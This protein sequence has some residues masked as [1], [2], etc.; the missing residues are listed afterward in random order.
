MRVRLKLGGHDAR[1]FETADLV[2][3]SPGVPHTLPMLEPA[4]VN[5]I[6]VVGEMELA[7]GYISEPMLAV[8]GTNGKTTTTELVG[9]MLKNSGK[10]VFVGG[11]IGTPL[12]AYADGAYPRADVV[13]VETSSFQLDT[14]IDFRPDTAVMLNI[15][16]D[17]LDRYATFSAYAESKWRIFNNQRPTDSAVLN[18][19][20]ATVAVMI[21]KHPPIARP[22]LFSDRAVEN[23]AQILKDQILMFTAGRQNGCF[24]L[25]KTG[26]M[27]PH[28]RENIAAACLACREQGATDDGIQ[29]A[30]DDCRGLSHRLE[31]VGRVGG[32]RFINDSKATNVDAV[33]RALEC[34]D[35]PVVLIMGGQNKKGDFTQLKLPVRQHVKTLVAMGEARDEIV[36]ALAGDPEKGILE[37]TSLEEAVEK[38]FGAAGTGE[39]VL[40]SPACASFDMFDNYAQRGSRF[41]KI[42]EGLV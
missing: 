10:K 37:A 16:D 17:H 32:V 7:A 33:K 23:G 24:S 11:N 38:A 15:T 1:D 18:A 19:M 5:G 22:Q 26:L 27:G 28:N 4:W 12:I 39:T 25:E 8:T 34:F 6:P 40:L 30:I 14:T 21:K 20:D 2:V 29:Q 9:R 36:T 31:T 35:T 42:V 13:V 3:L 41:R